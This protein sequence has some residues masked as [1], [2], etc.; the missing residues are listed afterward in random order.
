MGFNRFHKITFCWGLTLLNLHLYVKCG[1]E[2]VYSDAWQVSLHHVLVGILPDI[3]IENEF[4]NG[5]ES[6]NVSQLILSRLN[7]L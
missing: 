7:R 5:T 6:C 4:N 2:N 1:C 3:T